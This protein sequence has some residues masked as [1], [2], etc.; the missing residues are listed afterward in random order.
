[1][2]LHRVAYR[3]N[4]NKIPVVPTFV[5]FIQY[6]LY[7][8]SVPAQVKIGKGTKFAYGGIGVVIHERAVIGENCTIG[9][10]C[11]IGGRSK[12]YEVP[13]IGDNVYIGAGSRILGPVIIGNNVI[14]G[15]NAVVLENIASNCI[16]VGIPSKVVKTGIDTT[17]FI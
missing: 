7:N 15:P 11:T 1:M 6:L 13:I 3:L 4:R 17:D 16:A 12:H 8:S 2:F 5:Y 9:Q 14:V 10:G